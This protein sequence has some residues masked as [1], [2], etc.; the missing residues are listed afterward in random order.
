[1]GFRHILK[2]NEK[3]YIGNANMPTC[4]TRCYSVL[5]SFLQRT[6]ALFSGYALVLST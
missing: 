4:R 2:M 3:H 1:M 6:S 5:F